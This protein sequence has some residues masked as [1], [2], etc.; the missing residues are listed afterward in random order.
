[1]TRVFVYGTLMPGERAAH[2]VG[3]ARVERAEPAYLDGYD[4]Y[5]LEPEGYPAL[6]PGRGRVYGWRYTLPD[7]PWALSRLDAYEG[8]DLEPPLYTRALVRSEPGGVAAWVYLYAR[9]ERLALPTARLLP[10]GRWSD[11]APTFDS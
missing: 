7:A 10:E 5:A 2:V 9:A 1:M 6:V 8:L 4:L 3:G 11:D